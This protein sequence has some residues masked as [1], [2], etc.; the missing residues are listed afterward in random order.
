MNNYLQSVYVIEREDGLIKIGIASKPDKRVKTLSLQGGFNIVKQHFTEQCADART[1][2][3]ALHKAFADNKVK[4]EWFNAS[5]DDVVEA[6]SKFDYS[7]KT[8]Q[9]ISED[10]FNDIVDHLLGIIPVEKDNRLDEIEA[11][12]LSDFTEDYKYR[13]EEGIDTSQ[14]ETDYP[15]LCKGDEN[16]IEIEEYRQEIKSC[17]I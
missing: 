17:F 3:N 12:M 5:F 9:E 15:N 14:M 4:S 16:A 10:A 8:I 6:S 7:D 11:L 1:I 13:Q 2:E